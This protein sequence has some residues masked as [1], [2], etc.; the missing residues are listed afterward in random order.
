LGGGGDELAGVQRQVGGSMGT[1]AQEDDQKKRE[2]RKFHE[3][4]YSWEFEEC[5]KRNL[6]GYE[7]EDF[8]R[9]RF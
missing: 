7:I 4:D 2:E 1:I 5:V 8:C 9:L 3:R 6:K